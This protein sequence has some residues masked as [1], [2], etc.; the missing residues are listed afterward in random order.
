MQQE[1]RLDSIRTDLFY[2]LLDYT[3][4]FPDFSIPQRFLMASRKEGKE[5][6]ESVE[7]SLRG[8]KQILLYI[9]LPFCHS[10]CVFCN[11]SPHKGS[12]EIRSQYVEGLLKEIEIYS[13]SGMFDE[14]EAKCVY[15][16]GGTP[17]TFPSQDIRS[18]LDKVESYLDLAADCTITCEAHP[19]DLVENDKME[20]LS[21][22]GVGR[23]SIGCQTFDPK[24]L[25]LCTNIDMMIGLP[26]QTLEGVRR[27]LRVLSDIAPDSIEY[28]RHEIVNPLAISLYRSNPEFLVKDQELFQMVYDTQQWMEEKGYEQNGRFTS[29][30]QFSYRYHWLKEMPFIALGSRSRSCTKALCYDKHEDLS[31]YLR[32]IDK[33]VPPIA[34]Y[35]VFD[36]KEQMYRSLF[37]N[38]QVKRG[39][40]LGAFRKRFGEDPLGV[41]STLLKRLTE[42]GCVTA[43]DSSLRLKKYGRYFVEDVCCFIIDHALEEGG[44]DSRFKR[45]PHSS[46][47]YFS[48]W[49]SR[50]KSE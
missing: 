23:I 27:D 8:E 16:G 33:G 6:L 38:L 18:I 30:E 26:G 25:E 19:K 7:V 2:G 3:K 44:Y 31:L 35:L 11:A 17:T 4:S 29:E 37:L 41:F 45:V 34:R 24:V 32:L 50:L 47:A 42:L 40:D 13:K 48:S 12:R 10:E 46:G 5:L 28:M 22:L 49:P 43:D 39:L 14:K 36:K 9:H 1:S 15:F 21:Q 20:E